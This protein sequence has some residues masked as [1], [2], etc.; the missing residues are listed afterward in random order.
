MFEQVG[1]AAAALP[2]PLSIVLVRNP[3]NEH[4]TNAVEVHQP[5]VGMLGHLPRDI[6]ARVAPWLDAGHL[7]RVG[8]A[9]VL[10][11]PGEED[12]PVPDDLVW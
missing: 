4:D 9:S 8:V 11:M 2:E 5:A 10:V 3:A 6:A 1:Y 12:N 7:L